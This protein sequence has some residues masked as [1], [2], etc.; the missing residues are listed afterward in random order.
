MGRA[1]T[2]HPNGVPVQHLIEQAHAASMRD[3][4]FYPLT[5]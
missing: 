4:A 5:V 2:L 1:A 3:V